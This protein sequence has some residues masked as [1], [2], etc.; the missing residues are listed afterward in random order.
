MLPL[1]GEVVFYDGYAGAPVLRL[2]HCFLDFSSCACLVFI[3]LFKFNL[4]NSDVRH[5]QIYPLLVT[6]S[7]HL[8][9]TPNKPVSDSGQCLRRGTG[10]TDALCYR[11]DHLFVSPIQTLSVTLSRPEVSAESVHLPL[12]LV[13]DQYFQRDDTVMEATL[14][15]SDSSSVDRSPLG[16]F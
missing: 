7:P 15:R 3:G 1:F 4:P 9:A 6:S 8:N 12:R 10:S 5:F 14:E 11:S 13:Q 16:I 2:S